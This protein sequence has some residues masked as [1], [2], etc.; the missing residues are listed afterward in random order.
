MTIKSKAKWLDWKDLVYF[1]RNPFSS[2]MNNFLLNPS[3]ATFSNNPCNAGITLFAEGGCILTRMIPQYLL[4]G[5][6]NIFEKRNVFFGFYQFCCK[7]KDSFNG[8][9]PNR[10]I[11]FENLLRRFS[12]F[13]KFQDK[14]YH[15][16]CSFK[17]RLT[18]ADAGIKSDIIFNFH[19]NT[20]IMDK[21]YH[22]FKNLSSKA[23]RGR[24]SDT[25]LRRHT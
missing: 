4:G 19:L 8:I 18:M 5:Y 16:A 1:T 6:I 9:G 13:K 3:A 25:E 11:N 20:S 14:I 17:T 21:L 24:A 10:R 23:V 22:A 15:Y 12:C 7:V 2:R